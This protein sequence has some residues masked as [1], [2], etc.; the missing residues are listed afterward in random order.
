MVEGN[1]DEKG[2][3]QQDK[4]LMKQV[5][6]A[7]GLVPLV[8]AGIRILVVSDGNQATFLMLIRTLNLQALLLATYLPTLPT[9]G[10][11]LCGAAIVYRSS[12]YGD[13]DQQHLRRRL[14]TRMLP[15]VVLCS[16]FTAVAVEAIVLQIIA[17]VVYGLIGYSPAGLWEQAERYRARRRIASVLAWLGLSRWLD[18]QALG[19]VLIAIFPVLWAITF[20]MWLPANVVQFKDPNRER[21]G[22]VL[23]DEGG[24]ITALWRDGT[25]GSYED[26][27]I[28]TTRPCELG[29]N[30]WPN[31][32]PIVDV[33]MKGE[34]RRQLC[35]GLS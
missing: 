16:L 30:P 10:V 7:L 27:S 2:E 3:A 28:Q 5:G 20:A 22:W 17:I 18:L 4:S 13:R 15:V 34:S 8:L 14:A 33:I 11:V 19:L 31:G 24:R 21:V 35:P 9:F 23:E 26:G 29:A 25:V 12:L 6:V 32:R 1:R